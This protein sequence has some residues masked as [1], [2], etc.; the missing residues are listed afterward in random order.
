MIRRP[1]EAEDLEVSLP[2]K[3]EFRGINCMGRGA[4]IPGEGISE[5][6]NHETERNVVFP[7]NWKRNVVTLS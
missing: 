7:R 6:E 4:G 2:I 1:G 3:K 5:W